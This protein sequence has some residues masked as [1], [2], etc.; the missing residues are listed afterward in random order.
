M[1]NGKALEALAKAANII[2]DRK[3]LDSA[4]KLLNA[5]LVDVRNGG[6]T[7]KTAN[8]GW[9]YEEVAAYSEQ[10]EPRVLNGFM[11]ALLNIYSS[12]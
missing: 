5:F 2:G 10:K 3:Y 12:I 7:Y 11:F 6:L 4:K 1:A 9:W 8:D